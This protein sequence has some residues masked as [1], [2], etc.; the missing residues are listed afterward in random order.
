MMKLVGTFVAVGAAC[1]DDVERV[2]TRKM[3]D[4]FDAGLL[5]VAETYHQLLMQVRSAREE[6]GEQ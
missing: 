2:L 5:E 1:L 4:A 6:E 3:D